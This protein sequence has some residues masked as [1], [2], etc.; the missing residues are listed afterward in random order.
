MTDEGHD[1]GH[2]EH[3]PGRYMRGIGMLMQVALRM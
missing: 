1:W 3:K 2:N